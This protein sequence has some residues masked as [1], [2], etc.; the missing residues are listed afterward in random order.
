MY[1]TALI[2]CASA[3]ASL[4][5][6]AAPQDAVTTTS[7]QLA[8]ARHVMPKGDTSRRPTAAEL[9]QINAKETLIPIGRERLDALQ[10]QSGQV[11]GT[12][13]E[14]TQIRQNGGSGGD[15]TTQRISGPVCNTNINTGFAPSDIHGATGPAHMV[16]VT[17]VDIGVYNRT[18]CAIVS[19]QSLK[20]FFGVTLAAETLF[21]PRVVYDLKTGRFFVTVES[22]NSGNTD[23]RQY[24]AV[25]TN[26]LG[27]SYFRYTL[28]L[29]TGATR[30][31]KQA[32]NSFW[33]YPNVGYN[34][35]RWFITAN[36]FG[37]T[38]VVGALLT[39]NKAPTLTGGVTNVFC[40]SNLPS[41]LAPPIV[42]DNSTVATMLSPG[43]GGGSSVV[44]RDYLTNPTGNGSTDSLVVRPSYPITAWSTP[45]KAVQPNTRI[46]DTIDGR[47]QSASIQSLGSIWNVHAIGLGGRARVRMY[48]FS[49][50]SSV[51]SPAPAVVFT[52]FLVS[53]DDLWNPSMTTASGLVN[54]PAFINV[55]RTNRGLASTGRPS[56]VVFSGLNST[57]DA[58]FWS[59][60]TLRLSAFNF[61]TCPTPRGCRWGD[62][63]STQIDPLSAGRAWSWNQAVASPGSD[64]FDWITQAG[65]TEL[66]LRF[67]AEQKQAAK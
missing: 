48:K 55:S 46:I 12:G 3:L 63:S 1:K 42:L 7:I 38:N 49:N 52:P 21:D 31:C 43:S 60:D 9:K 62:Y 18:S 37:T 35:Q 50:A 65:P 29:S 61:A 47:F 15:V 11:R 44:R 59:A 26:N 16:V 14:G 40:R 32:A 64:Q 66:V 8:P 67:G 56:H 22:R 54:A 5:A 19:R 33:D 36:D 51:F 30:F 13:R 45:P 4:S 41:N 34:N 24:F 20:A 10:K 53:G 58:T 17:N 2:A 25:S 39:I 23:Q 28:R 6:F 27:T 57:T